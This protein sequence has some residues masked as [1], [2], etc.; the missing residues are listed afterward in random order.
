MLIVSFTTTLKRTLG[1]HAYCPL[2]SLV[3]NE[4]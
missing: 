2:M 4:V 1:A 3:G